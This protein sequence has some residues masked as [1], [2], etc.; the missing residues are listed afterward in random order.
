MGKMY[1]QIWSRN[2]KNSMTEFKVEYKVKEEIYLECIRETY[3]RMNLDVESEK[4]R[5]W[6]WN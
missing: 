6:T 4:V 3:L 5:K 1:K 2:L